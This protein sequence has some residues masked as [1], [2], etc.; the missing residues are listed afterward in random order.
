MTG[1]PILVIERTIEMG[2]SPSLGKRP[3]QIAAA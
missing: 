1:R 2:T 3:E